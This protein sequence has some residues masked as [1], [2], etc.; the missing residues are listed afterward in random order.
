M[1]KIGENL[2]EKLLLVADRRSHPAVLAG[3]LSQFGYAITTVEETPR[4]LDVLARESPDLVIIDSAYTRT[5]GLEICF[6]LKTN[7]FTSHIPIIIIGANSASDERVQWFNHGADVCLDSPFHPAELVARTRALL[8]RSVSY[9]SLTHL[10]TAAYLHRQLDA[11]LA[12]NLPTAVLYVDID[13]L[14]DFITAYGQEAADRVVMRLAELTVNALPRGNVA[15]AHLGRDQF[16]A[17][18][19]PAGSQTIAQTLVEQ[20]RVLR[21]QFYPPPYSQPGYT[22]L[23]QLLGSQRQGP[24][25]TLS[26]VLV[27]NERRVLLSY[28][29]VSSLVIDLLHK[30][31][32]RG[33]DSWENG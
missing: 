22:E 11:W 12:N 7:A 25:L 21:S 17:V 19:S 28:V 29:Q 3:I 18:L 14:Q 24:T 8:R 23:I 26:A 33:G 1:E 4:A 6:H 13:H 32:Q 31:K 30:V 20:F 2:R 5:G 27:T 15:V 10:P 16:M 9:D